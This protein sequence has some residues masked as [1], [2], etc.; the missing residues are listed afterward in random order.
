MA[1]VMVVDDEA[2][3]TTELG[4]YL[5]S[6]GYEVESASSGEEAVEK[7]KHF[8]P[9]VIFMDII[10]P[11][12]LDGIVASELIKRELDSPVIFLT[13]YANDA[14]IKRAKKV[15]PFG[16]I[17]KPYRE[18]EIKAFLEI[19]LHRKDIQ[20]SI[21]K[22][23]NEYRK[24]LQQTI[25]STITTLE[26]IMETRIPEVTHHQRR[27]AQLALAIAKEMS[28]IEERVRG[29]HVATR[30]HDIGEIYVPSEIIRMP[31]R[32]SRV[33][34]ATVKI[35]PQAGYDTLKETNF[36]WP[37]AQI[38]LQHHERLD[39]SGYPQGLS[40]KEI[41]LEA[42]I[43]GV[44]DVVEAMSSSRPNRE[45]LGIDIALEETSKNRGILYHPQVVDAC[46]KL[47]TEKGFKFE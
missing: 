16:Y 9:D 14:L 10:M 18:A 41:M 3:I 27:V 38:I 24:K 11:G 1:R 13:S 34:F 39:G 17:L 12:T 43:L 40:G 45:A 22:E 19:T 35:H 5:K 29:A 47:F 2:I 37:V 46:L 20:R 7:A 32:F 26:R 42:R 23:L 31:G 4:T 36:A 28:L 25:E 8:R 33:E 15:E 21:A 44:A 30:I 6:L